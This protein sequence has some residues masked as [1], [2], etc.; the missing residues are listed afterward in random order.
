MQIIIQ[1]PEAATVQR[2]F[3]GL[4]TEQSVRPIVKIIIDIDPVN[5]L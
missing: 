3:A 5:L 1:G 2:L 4:R